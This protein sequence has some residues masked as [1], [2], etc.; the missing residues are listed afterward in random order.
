MTTAVRLV[1]WCSPLE[2]VRLIRRAGRGAWRT[3]GSSDGRE[4]DRSLAEHDVGTD[5]LLK[6]T[7]FVVCTDRADLIRVWD[8]VSSRLGRAPSTLLGVTLLGYP[9]QLVEIEG[10][11]V[12]D[13][14][15]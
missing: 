10:I 13:T 14:G 4:P 9:D 2:R 12:I 1:G 7:V 3:P 15:L 6:T 5:A 8:V 11:A